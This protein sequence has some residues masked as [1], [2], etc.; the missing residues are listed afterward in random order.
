MAQGCSD[1]N[2]A[3]RH[4]RGLLST[5]PHPHAPD[6]PPQGLAV[7]GG[8]K[9]VP[10]AFPRSTASGQPKR[11]HS[12]AGQPASPLKPFNRETFSCDAMQVVPGAWSGEYNELS[13]EGKQDMAIAFGAFTSWLRLS[14][15]RGSKAKFQHLDRSIMGPDVAPSWGFWEADRK[16]AQDVAVYSRQEQANLARS[17]EFSLPPPPPPRAAGMVPGMRNLPTVRGAAL[18]LAGVGSG[19]WQVD[20][21]LTDPFPLR[22]PRTAIGA[23]VLPGLAPGLRL[24]AGQRTAH[25]RPGGGRKQGLRDRVTRGGPRLCRCVTPSLTQRMTSPTP[26]APV[27]ER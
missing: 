9:V 27:G 12:A 23:A 1:Q 26:E 18:P 3:F 25:V 8:P 24:G 20:P 4:P 17:Q 14:T 15:E 19:S 11:E 6:P 13:Q 21:V 2:T 10:R 22:A 5:P 7:A 16:Q